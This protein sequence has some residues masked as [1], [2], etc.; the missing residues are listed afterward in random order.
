[1]IMQSSDVI[2]AHPR[3]KQARVLLSSVFGPYAQDDEFGS[4][5]INP[6]ELY[7]NQVTRAQGSFS[8]RMF[9]RSWGLMMIQRNI[10]APS[11]LLDFPTLDR[12]QKEL[13]ST[14]Y[15][16][17]GISGIIPNFGK[18]R[19]MCRQVRKLS[20]L[21]SIIVG[22][23]VA[24][25]PGID[26]LIDADYFVRGEGIGWMRRYLGDDC[27]API[28]HPEIMSGFG[29]RVLGIGTPDS[30]RDTAATIIPSVGCPMGCNFCTTSAFFGGKGKSFH[31]FESGDEIFEVME[32][33]EHAMNVRSFFIMDENFLLQRPRAMQL[34]ER[35]KQADKSWSLYVF[36]SVNAIRRYSM[37]ELVQLGISWIWLGLESPN[38]TYSKLRQADTLALAAELRQHGIKLLGS[39]IVGLEHHTPQNIEQEIEHA[40]AHC[41]DFHQFMLYT[42]VPGTPLYEQVTREGRMLE[43]VD[44][45]D[46]HGQF[47]FNFQ[48]A[49]I[50]REQSKHFLDWAFQFDFDRNG[51]SLFRIS[52]TIFQGWKRYRNS[53]DARVRERMRFEA[54]KL[55]TTY[56]AA[57][58]AMEKRL[59]NTNATV[60]ARIRELRREIEH[61]FGL[62]TRSLRMVVGP[63]LLWTSKRED[64]RLAAGKTYEPPTFVERRNWAGA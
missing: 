22:G 55:R 45:A 59:H 26:K 21:S 42:P 7:H 57:L 60:S 40:V 3:G 64:R 53:P 31:F 1:M 62:A 18:V 47:K 63:L 11:T 29:M 37:E 6:M 17:V 32:H 44:L 20:P 56:N 46:I 8:L 34:L 27:E 10:S 41:T 39:T 13:T 16:V 2:A 43:D 4:R 15:D 49:A 38:S 24:A 48:H 61:E 35:M 30:T 36:S 12:F 28:E 5:A 50:S 58:W 51:P 52:E 19:E 14:A 33:M 25:I 9:H 54:T 23:H